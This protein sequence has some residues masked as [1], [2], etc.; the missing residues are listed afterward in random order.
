MGKPAENLGRIRVADGRVCYESTTYPS[1]VVPLDDLRIVGEMT[2][3]NGPFC[4]D[5]FLVFARDASGWHEAPTGA[6]GI[7]SALAA[8][9]ERL[10][11]R[12]ECTLVY[13]THFASVVLWPPALAGQAMFS[14]TPAKRKGLWARLKG[15][16]SFPIMEQTYAPEIEAF[17]SCGS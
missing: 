14:F 2:N 1:W 15:L 5:H 4:E 7:D 12:L 6:A 17:L 8:I 9:G 11:A 10:G 13:E 16:L 3:E